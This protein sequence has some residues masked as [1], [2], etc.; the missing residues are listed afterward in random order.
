[1]RIYEFKRQARVEEIR[2][3]LKNMEID[4]EPMDLKKI[5]TAISAHYNVSRKTAGDYMEAA[6]F[7][8]DSLG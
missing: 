6:K 7:K 1:M 4:G 5:I 8:N 3:L 2:E